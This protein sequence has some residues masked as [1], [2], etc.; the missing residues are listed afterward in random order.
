MCVC[1][2]IILLVVLISKKTLGYYY[3]VSIPQDITDGDPRPSTW[4]TPSA[5]LSP[6]GCDI[7]SFFFNHSV[8]FGKLDLS[9]II[10][11]FRDLMIMLYFRYHILR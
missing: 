11:D 7:D 8:I 5:A 2:L 3:R 1:P 4:T 9:Y 6:K 10:I